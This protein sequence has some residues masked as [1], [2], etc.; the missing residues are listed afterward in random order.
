MAIA[1]DSG[2]LVVGF[3]GST[4]AR[5]ALAFARDHAHGRRV[6]VVHAYDPLPDFYGAPNYG[7]ILRARLDRGREVLGEAEAALGEADHDLELLEGPAAAA[8]AHVAT[9]RAADAIVVGSRGLGRLRATLGS[10]SHELL[11]LA[12]RPVIVVPARAGDRAA[13]TGAS[14]A[15]G[16]GSS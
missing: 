5:D 14:A 11:H 10:V 1:T 3:D 9:T 16:T 13:P 7:E 8:I 6:V 4:T 2:T 12:E 15:A